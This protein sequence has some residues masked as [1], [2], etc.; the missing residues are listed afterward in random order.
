MRLL[1]EEILNV[2]EKFYP[3]GLS[4][5]HIINELPGDKKPKESL[6]TSIL[7]E[8]LDEEVI[9]VDYSKGLWYAE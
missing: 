7:S 1:K 5:R 2:L 8:L 6:V 4:I 3:T 9:D